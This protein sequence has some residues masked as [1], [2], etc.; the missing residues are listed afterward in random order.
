MGRQATLRRQAK[1]SQARKENQA[2]QNGRKSNGKKPQQ[3]FPLWT[4]ISIAVV[5]VAVVGVVIVARF[6]SAQTAVANSSQPG[7]TIDGISCDQQEGSVEHIHAHLTMYINGS[8]VTV[9]PDIGS[10]TS[11]G[12]LYWLHTHNIQGDSGV[13][14]IEAPVTQPF[15]VGNFAD[16]WGKQFQQLQYPFELSQANGWQAY[17]N[18]KPYTGSWRNIPLQNHAAIT[19]AY[20]SPN[21]KPD[22]SFNFISGE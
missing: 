17:I 13:I 16:I 2:Y 8:K 11:A 12:C 7:A 18:G 20:N 9:P 3:K 4:L 10:V 5:I 15:T 22:T 1:Q 6:F 19:I 14:H 21:I